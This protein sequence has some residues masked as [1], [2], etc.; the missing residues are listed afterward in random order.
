MTLRHLD[1][2]VLLIAAILSGCAQRAGDEVRILSRGLAGQQP[3]VEQVAQMPFADLS[4][5]AEQETPIAMTEM[6]VRYITGRDVE[7]DEARAIEL[8]RQSAARD[9]PTASFNLGVAYASGIG[10][11]QDDREAMKWYG[12]AEKLGNID[13]AYWSGMM[14]GWG[15]GGMPESWESARPHIEKAAAADHVDAQF[16]MGWM[17]HE[18]NGVER[19]YQKAANWYRRATSKV[20]NQ[21]AQYNLLMLINEQKVVWQIGDPGE[22]SKSGQQGSTG[23]E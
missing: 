1:W 20:L 9:E 19:D 12:Q 16:Q 10:V 6:A 13:A 17:Y 14:I 22:A 5:L 11:P 7:K 3:T 15:R 8:F 4:A 18:G 21:K 23:L 2:P